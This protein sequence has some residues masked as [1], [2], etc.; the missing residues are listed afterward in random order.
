MT[1]TSEFGRDHDLTEELAPAPALDE[2]STGGERRGRYHSVKEAIQPRNHFL[3]R[4]RKMFSAKITTSHIVVAL[5]LM[6][7]GFSM[8]NQ[9]STETDQSLA[10]LSEA[11]LVQ[12]LDDLRTRTDKLNQERYDL[13]TQ[14]RQLQSDSSTQEQARRAAQERKRV[15]EIMSGSTPVSGSGILILVEDHRRQVPADVFVNLLGELRNAGSEAIDISGQRVVASTW[16]AKRGDELV[17]DGQKISPPYRI[18]VLGEPHTLAV[19]LG[20][21]G[22]SIARFK[23]YDATVSVEEKQKLQIDSIHQVDTPQWAQVVE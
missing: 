9:L 23:Q 8:V 20:I 6:V 11:D 7:F 5:L 15:I 10:R 22:G 3:T 16:I 18:T 21:P 17:V 12:L 19:A 13:E 14:L 2:Q 1:E 4:I